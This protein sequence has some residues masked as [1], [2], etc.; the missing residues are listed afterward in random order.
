MK[1]RIKEASIGANFSLNG[2]MYSPIK[3]CKQNN[4]P[5]MNYYY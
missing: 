2:Q 5:G 3:P 4:K 1:K